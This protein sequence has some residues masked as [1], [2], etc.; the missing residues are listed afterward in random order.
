MNKKI[1]K[2]ILII[3]MIQMKWFDPSLTIYKCK[4]QTKLILVEA[5]RCLQVI[6]TFKEC[7]ETKFSKLPQI[8]LYAICN[9]I[10][11]KSPKSCR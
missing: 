2:I 1:L 11:V 5:G 8:W 10:G 4:D 7:K 6:L 3:I 9:L